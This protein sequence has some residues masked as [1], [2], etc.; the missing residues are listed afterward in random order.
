MSPTGYDAP[1]SPVG[2]L[3][4]LISPGTHDELVR[5]TVRLARLTFS[6]TAA[7]AFLYDENAGQL[8]FEAS[9]G[10]GEDR[11]AGIAIPAEHGI[12]GWV[13]QSGETMIAEDVTHDPRFAREFA[14]STGYVPSTIMAAPLEL[15]DQTIGVLEVLDP[16][17]DRFGDLAAIDLLTE[18]AAQSAGALS[19]LAAARCFARST[20]DGPAVGPWQQ[21]E[22][23][24]RQRPASEMAIREFI[25]A[26][27]NLVA[28]QAL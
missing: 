26:L 11:L 17:L 4:R 9:S 24:F 22:L 16:V 20:A 14:E 25:R 23:A 5:S 19:L 27:G 3:G 1:D 18:L 10:P 2:A 8:V 28:S 15:G 6:A 21:L 12:A 13:F 7:S